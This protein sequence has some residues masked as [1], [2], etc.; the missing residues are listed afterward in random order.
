MQMSN[1]TSPK[2]L[3]FHLLPE[4]LCQFKNVPSVRARGETI[5]NPKV[6]LNTSDFDELEE[7]ELK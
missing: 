2:V 6:K 3:T 7:R 1:R 5:R 4:I